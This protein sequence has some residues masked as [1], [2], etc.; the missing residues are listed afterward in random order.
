VVEDNSL[1]TTS[2]KRKY[3]NVGMVVTS[4]QL[5]ARSYMCKGH[6]KT[7]RLDMQEKASNMDVKGRDRTV[8]IT[9]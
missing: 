5:Y 4:T 9:F 6:D 2:D 3:G 8:K 7:G 1:D